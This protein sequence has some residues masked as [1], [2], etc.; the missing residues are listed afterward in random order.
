MAKKID[1]EIYEWFCGRKILEFGESFKKEFGESPFDRKYAF[2]EDIREEKT[3]F[4]FA[5]S[6]P[7]E[8]VDDYL[9][10]LKRVLENCDFYE[11]SDPKFLRMF[12][13]REVSEVTDKI[14]DKHFPNTTDI[15]IKLHY[16]A[17]TI[18]KIFVLW[19]YSK[20]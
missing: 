12:N 14:Y 9:S 4:K 8:R 7:L 19:Y 11:G 5:I 13:A 1:D 2:A 3:G 15:I 17:S 20:L 10:R 6:V 18:C 16:N